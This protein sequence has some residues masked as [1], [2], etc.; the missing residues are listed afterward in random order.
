MLLCVWSLCNSNYE[1]NVRRI[2]L[3]L[4]DAHFLPVEMCLTT[5]YT[6]A[7]A[8]IYTLLFSL[9]NQ[10]ISAPYCIVAMFVYTTSSPHTVDAYPPA[11]LQKILS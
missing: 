2:S 3:L 1:C 5:Q 8:Y 4:L 10:R 9:D 7:E 11:I 6:I